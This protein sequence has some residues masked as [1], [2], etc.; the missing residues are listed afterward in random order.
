MLTSRWLIKAANRYR[1]SA[2]SGYAPLT[3]VQ[4]LIAP[5]FEAKHFSSAPDENLLVKQQNGL[6]SITINR[7]KALNAKNCGKLFRP[8]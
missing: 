5:V 7:P 4:Q 6:G 2:A 1:S 3:Q 8:C